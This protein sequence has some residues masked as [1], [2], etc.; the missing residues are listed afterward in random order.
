MLYD[1]YEL[2]QYFVVIFDR[3]FIFVC[4]SR[5]H[6]VYVINVYYKTGGKILSKNV[7]TLHNQYQLAVPLKVI[8]RQHFYN[9]R[10]H[11][12]RTMCC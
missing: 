6:L 9:L 10:L 5:L 12:I 7:Y 8:F 1:G 11:F 3:C 2:L 4:Q